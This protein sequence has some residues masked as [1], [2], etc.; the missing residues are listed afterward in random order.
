MPGADKPQPTSI[1]AAAMTAMAS[2]TTVIMPVSTQRCGVLVAPNAATL[3]SA[4]P[5]NRP[6][7]WSGCKVVGR[8]TI[9]NAARAASMAALPKK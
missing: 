1:A 3:T 4:K 5:A 8:A 6:S 9:M 7:R 2:I